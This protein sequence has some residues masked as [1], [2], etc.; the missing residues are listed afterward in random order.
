VGA[1]VAAE[2]GPPGTPTVIAYG[3]VCGVGHAASGARPCAV[4][5]RATAP[6]TTP[7]MAEPKMAL[8]IVTPSSI[9]VP[10]F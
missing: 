7:P 2:L 9:E 4:A 6:A 8:I 1:D 10:E 5:T 3:L